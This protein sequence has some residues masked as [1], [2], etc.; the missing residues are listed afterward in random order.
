MKFS[1]ALFSLKNKFWEEYKENEG[2]MGI[3]DGV[4]K[5]ELIMFF[6]DKADE[7]ISERIRAYNI[8][9]WQSVEPMG[10]LEDLLELRS[11]TNQ[12]PTDLILECI[13]YYKNND[14]NSAGQLVM[15]YE[16]SNGMEGYNFSNEVLKIEDIAEKY[17]DFPLELIGEF[18]DYLES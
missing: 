6:N 17:E 2:G 18:L 11:S 12:L 7:K 1:D 8:K 14:K 9:N 15:Y 4:L 3:I 16:K 5:D 10:M 13:N